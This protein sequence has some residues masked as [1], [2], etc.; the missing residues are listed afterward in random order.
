MERNGLFLRADAATIAP[1]R[2]V[3]PDPTRHRRYQSRWTVGRQSDDSI[4]VPARHGIFINDIIDC[5]GNVGPRDAQV[6]SAIDLF[7]HERIAHTGRTGRDC[8]GRRRP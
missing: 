3:V 8:Q 2:E 7:D 1:D 4:E 6:G 5:R